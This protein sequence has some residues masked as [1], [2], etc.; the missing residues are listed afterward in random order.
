[1]E[2]APR[3]WDVTSIPRLHAQH[4]RQFNDAVNGP[5]PLCVAP[6]HGVNDS[7]TSNPYGDVDVYMHHTVMSAYYALAQAAWGRETLSVLD[8]G[9]GVGHYAVLFR[10]LF[11]QITFD[12]SVKDVPSMVME[13]RRLLPDVTYYDDDA[14]C[15][16]RTYDFVL[17]SASFQYMRNWHEDLSTLAR[18]S[19]SYLYVSQIPIVHNVSSFVVMQRPYGH[20]YDTEYLGWCFQRTEFLDTACAAGLTLVREVLHGFKPD[21]HG[22]PE[23]PEYRGFLFRRAH[24]QQA[25]ASGDSGA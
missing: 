8:W 2:N 7:V 12:Y 18:A 13:G 20:G 4:W 23:A 15:F 6:E 16:Q 5:Q 10:A 24:G 9:G 21:V 14:Q 17:A 11:P 22:A 19:D 3:G 1:V 25:V